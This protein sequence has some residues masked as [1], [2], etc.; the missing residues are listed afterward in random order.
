MDLESSHI[1]VNFINFYA[2]FIFMNLYSEF[3]VISI[4]L[5]YMFQTN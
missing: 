4:D 3:P 1:N 2:L 5:L